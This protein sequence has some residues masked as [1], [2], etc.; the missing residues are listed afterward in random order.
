MTYSNGKLIFKRNLNI[1]FVEKQTPNE[2]FGRT[3]V[4]KIFNKSVELNF[5]RL[6][7]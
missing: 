6:I 5:K 7:V 4:L 3:T 1:K 2:Y